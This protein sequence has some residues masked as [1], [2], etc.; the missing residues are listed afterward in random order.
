MLGTTPP[1][2]APANSISG[3]YCTD[4]SA[5]N[6][7]ATL[8]PEYPHMAYWFIVPSLGGEPP[9]LT[10]RFGWPLSP[11]LELDRD[12]IARMESIVA[13]PD[14]TPAPYEPVGL[15][16]PAPPPASPDQAQ[17]T[18]G[19]QGQSAWTDRSWDWHQV[20]DCYMESDKIKEALAQL[21]GCTLW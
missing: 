20:M 18:P 1:S 17:L 11:P 6:S 16:N 3:E 13:W 8:P 4:S 10:C 21:S 2:T 9:I 12:R 14:W 7:V 15:Q 19:F 5:A